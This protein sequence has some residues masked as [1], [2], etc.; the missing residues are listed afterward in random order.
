M[1]SLFGRV[2]Q[3]N[4]T[5]GWTLPC[6]YTCVFVRILHCLHGARSVI[7]AGVFCSCMQCKPAMGEER[8][9]PSNT[10]SKS[11]YSR[12]WGRQQR[13]CHRTAGDAG[14][15]LSFAET[16]RQTLLLWG[17]IIKLHAAPVKEPMRPNVS[18]LVQSLLVNVWRELGSL[19]V[20]VRFEN[21]IALDNGRMAVDL[22]WIQSDPRIL[23]EQIVFNV[24][25]GNGW[26]S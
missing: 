15:P 14:S 7:T 10:V 9:G 21:L 13:W 22:A 3:W 24:K 19:L 2:T 12:C 18:G 17:V 16:E 26:S 11:K 4:H 25:S 8:A 1:R 20:V 6:T 23:S 5:K